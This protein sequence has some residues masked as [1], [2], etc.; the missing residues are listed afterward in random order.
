MRYLV[1]I[2]VLF[3]SCQNPT[4]NDKPQGASDNSVVHDYKITFE[5][6]DGIIECDS[7]EYNFNEDILILHQTPCGEG[8]P[9]FSKFLATHYF[10][11]K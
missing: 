6:Y 4:S 9:E 3:L 11:I 1:L 8:I 7:L 10:K 2:L 5:T